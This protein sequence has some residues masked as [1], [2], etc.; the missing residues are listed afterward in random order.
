MTL[1]QRVYQ[2]EQQISRLRGK[3]E[4]WITAQE[5]N[6]LTGRDKHWLKRQRDNR[7][8]SF[9]ESETGGLLYLYESIPAIYLKKNPADR[10]G[11]Q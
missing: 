8:I 5:V 11:I 7:L 9:K 4:T 1:E 10:Q 2:L 6:R 3:Q